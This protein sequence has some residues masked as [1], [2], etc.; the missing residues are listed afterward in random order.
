MASRRD[1]IDPE[2]FGNEAGEDEDSEVLSSYF[3]EKSDFERFFSANTRLAFANRVRHTQASTPP[4]PPGDALQIPQR[5]NAEPATR[6]PARRG[7]L[8][9]NRTTG[10]G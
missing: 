5:P 9:P 4:Q 7:P 8:A 3:V 2:L 1:L 6:A 10:S